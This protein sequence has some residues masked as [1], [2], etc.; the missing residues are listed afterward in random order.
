MSANR[1]ASAE[2][3]PRHG[4][5]SP[6]RRTALVLGGSGAHGAYHAGVLRALQE[7][8]VKIDLLAGQGVGA[9]SAALAAVDGAA[10]LWAADGL[11]RSPSS[12]RLYCWA[13]PVKVAACAAVAALLLLLAPLALLVPG[14]FV[15]P[16]VVWMTMV[17]LAGLAALLGA[18]AVVL[19]R[20]RRQGRRVAGTWWW[21][22]LGAPFD[23][24]PLRRAFASAIW[25]TLKGAAPLAE[26]SPAA[27]GSRY[28]EVLQENL[29]QPG[30]RELILVATDLDARR[31]L[32]AALLREPYRQP[33]TSST[34]GKER[35]ADVLDLAGVGREHT[36]DVIAAAVTPPIVFEP[37]P[38]TFA[39][40][41]YWRGETHRTCD[42]PGSL[43]RLLDEVAAAGAT[44][45]I[46]VSAVAPVPRPHQ[47]RAPRIDL[48]GRLS[49]L[50][51][52]AEAAALRDGLE[53]AR[54]RFEAVHLI[55][56]AHNPVGPFDL[57]GAFDDASDR[58]QD[59]TELMERAYEDAYRQFIDPIVGGSGEHLAAAAVDGPDA[60]G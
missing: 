34:A 52:A 47:L 59:L 60:F 24:Q 55:A 21:Q 44:Q 19:A 10:R 8:G 14:S 50:Q 18:T 35:R 7:V 40:A 22:V 29:G 16:R 11:W 31:D 23:A 41:S 43:I 28:G 26:P 36:L 9:G 25:E 38:F 56:P 1:P 12:A 15:Q 5:Y 27:I 58:R 51:V 6:S 57:S 54:R 49:E 42:R 4:S 45:A 48:R 3:A 30:F 53:A 20:R 32:V 17:G 39:A 46:V 13:G 2:A 33:F 37:H